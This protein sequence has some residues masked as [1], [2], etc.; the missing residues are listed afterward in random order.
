MCLVLHYV[1]HSIIMYIYTYLNMYVYMCTACVNTDAPL[2]TIRFHSNKS[3]VIE[4]I[5]SGKYTLPYWI[6]AYWHTYCS[7]QYCL[8]S[9]SGS[10]VGGPVG[11]CCPASQENTVLHMAGSGEDQNSRLQV[12]FLLNTYC[13]CITEKTNYH[14]AGAAD[15]IL[16]PIDHFLK[17]YF[18]WQLSVLGM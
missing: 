18:Y 5:V 11:Y 10:S 17:V 14:K 16:M 6:S 1:L 13:F 2:F 12:W 7:C 4:S 3:V 9:W 15:S 8:I